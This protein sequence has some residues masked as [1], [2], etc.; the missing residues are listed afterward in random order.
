MKE[1]D[2]IIS[3]LIFF[4]IILAFLALTAWTFYITRNAWSFAIL[5]MLSGLRM[6][7]S[8]VENDKDRDKD[9]KA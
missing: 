6:T 1:L 8:S 3:N 2:S 7:N 4:L 5:I 9:I